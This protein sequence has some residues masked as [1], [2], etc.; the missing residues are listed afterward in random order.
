[1]PRLLRVLGMLVVAGGLVGVGWWA[2]SVAL[3]PPVDPVGEPEPVSYV[4]EVGSV[5]RALSFAAVGEWR[6]EALARNAAN[7]VVTSVDVEPGSMVVAGDVLYSVDLRPVVAAEGVV[8]SF[9]DLTLRD[10][11][12][13]VAQLQGLLTDLGFYEGEADG[14]FGVGVRDAVQEWQRSLGVTDDGVVRRGDVVYVGGLPARVLLSEEVTVGGLL[15][16]GEQVV[17]R[18]VGEVEFSVPLTP[19]QRGL[20]PLVAEVEVTYDGGVWE[21]R[22]VEAVERPG[23]FGEEL[24]LVLEGRGGGSLCGED[25]GVV[26]LVGRSSFPA[27]IIVVP[28]TSGPVVPVAGIITEADGSTVVQTTDGRRIEVE[29]VAAADGLAVV[30]GLEPGEVILLP[31]AG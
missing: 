20:V 29:V 2:G 25:C 15:G 5:G 18:V 12:S 9:R 24:A 10:R 26:P 6:L 14:V 23:E 17:S 8:P 21:G 28:E 4:V 31:V 1:M 19:E 27:R 3:R 13:D 16:G 22:I 7:G 30:E 11:G